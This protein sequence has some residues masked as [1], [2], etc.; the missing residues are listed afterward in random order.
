M[1]SANQVALNEGR[2]SYNQFGSMAAHKFT[3]YGNDEDLDPNC[4][5][6]D[7]GLI[8]AGYQVQVR[9]PYIINNPEAFVT[10][11][12]GEQ[13]TT[14]SDPADDCIII[15]CTTWLWASYDA[16]VSDIDWDPA[17]DLPDIWDHAKIIDETYYE[18]Y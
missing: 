8:K 12:F 17:V 14:Y 5:Y 2:I 4:D 18:A 1:A 16:T 15:T 10:K 7:F 6:T 11:C 13:F 9:Y 3:R